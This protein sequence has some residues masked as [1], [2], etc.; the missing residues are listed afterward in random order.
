MA[1]PHWAIAQDGSSAETSL[2]ACLA[3]SYWKECSR[4][5]ARSKP[6]CAAFEHEVKR[7]TEP[8]SSAESSWWCPCA[9]SVR[10]AIKKNATSKI[11]VR[12]IGFLLR[13]RF[14]ITGK[15]NEECLRKY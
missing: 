3:C 7:W 13:K 1:T 6:G 11:V 14:E 8:I 5:T 10:E 9:A 15:Q 2:N 12:R 4:A